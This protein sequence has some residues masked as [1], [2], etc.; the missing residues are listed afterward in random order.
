[1]DALALSSIVTML[2]RTKGPNI[3][4]FNL[5][6]VQL[7]AIQ[8]FSAFNSRKTS[9]SSISIVTS[10]S[11]STSQKALYISTAQLL[12][13]KYTKRF[14]VYSGH[15][16]KLISTLCGQIAYFLNGEAGDTYNYHYTPGSRSRIANQ[17]KVATIVT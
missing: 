3:F 12:S 6:L 9:L 14:S 7:I 4:I 5:P 11:V 2:E 8:D 17:I 13:T 1:M 15:H 16:S 10:S